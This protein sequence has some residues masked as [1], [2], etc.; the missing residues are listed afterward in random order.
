MIFICAQPASKYYAWQVDTMLYSFRKLNLFKENQA[1]IVCSEHQ[2]KN[3]FAKLINKYPEAQFYFYNDTRINPQY[4]SSIRL[5]LLE[6]H[7]RK[8]P[9]LSN[10]KFFYHDCDIVLNKMPNIPRDGK[11]YL[12]DTK[13]YIGYE[14]IKSKGQDVLDLMCDVAGVNEQMLKDNDNGSGGAQYVFSNVDWYFWNEAYRDSESLFVKL[15]KLNQM[16]TKQDSKYHPLQIWTADMWAVLWNFWKRG[17]STHLLK[18]LDFCW[19]TDAI[20]R[21]DFT[22]ICHNAGVSIRNEDLFFKGKY[23]NDKPP[24]G[25]QI[26]NKKVSH[27]YYQVVCEAIYN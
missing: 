14:Y 18:E 25:L 7:W 19:S 5:N 16:K 21:W 6:Q 9:F 1:H 20:E 8:Y 13:S 11:I 22:N 12:S 3:E 24:K 27:K 15:T 2:D 26:N 4:I 23:I 17:K 10:S